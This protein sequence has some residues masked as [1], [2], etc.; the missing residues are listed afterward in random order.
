MAAA[1]AMRRN[2]PLLLLP[3]PECQ[4]L[5]PHNKHPSDNLTKTRN[6]QYV[7]LRTKD[8]VGPCAD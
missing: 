2:Q 5:G 7:Q 4:T 8:Y 3:P 1:D 6:D